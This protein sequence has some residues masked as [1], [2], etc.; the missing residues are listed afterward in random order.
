MSTLLFGG[1][2]QIWLPSCRPVQ[3]QYSSHS[4]R[5]CFCFTHTL[6]LTSVT[7]QQCSHSGKLV[8]YI[9]YYLYD[10][11]Q[12]S[13]LTSAIIFDTLFILLIPQLT[14]KFVCY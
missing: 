8:R 6:T 5:L 2:V 9:L 10:L 3:L 13:S 1:T 11:E 14:I 12:Y 4:T 7:L